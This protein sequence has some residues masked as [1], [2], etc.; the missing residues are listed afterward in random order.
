MRRFIKLAGLFIAG[1]ALL[2][3][4][5]AGLSI[6]LS[7]RLDPFFEVIVFVYLPTIRLVELRGPYVGDANIIYPI[8]YGVLLG[9]PLYGI[10]AAAAVCLLKRRK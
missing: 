10:I 8:F 3:T 5:V 2:W 4:I 6:W 9:I 1:Q 7:P